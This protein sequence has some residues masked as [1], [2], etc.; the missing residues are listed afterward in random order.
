M[1]ESSR[2][3]IQTAWSTN[4]DLILYEYAVE[5]KCSLISLFHSIYFIFHYVL[6]A[7]ISS[8][9]LSIIIIFHYYLSLVLT[10]FKDFN[11][12]SSVLVRMSSS[13]CFKRFLHFSQ[14]Y[15]ITHHTAIL[16]YGII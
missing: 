8:F 3:K 15:L 14:T 9:V 12:C 1:E 2:E 10:H 5:S 6:V 4:V 7:T 11:K 16:S 13:F